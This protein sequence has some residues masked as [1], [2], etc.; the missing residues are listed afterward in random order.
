MIRK[1]IGMAVAAAALAAS[2]TAMAGFNEQATDSHDALNQVFDPSLPAPGGVTFTGTY[3]TLGTITLD[4]SVSASWKVTYT[5][6]GRE[7]AYKD[8]MVFDMGAGSFTNKNTALGA[9]F[10]FTQSAGLMDFQFYD[11]MGYGTANGDVFGT[12]PLISW[13]LLDG[14]SS[15]YGPFDYII[16]LNDSAGGN[17]R[18]YDDMVIGITVTPVPEPE[19]YALMLAGLGCVTLVARRR[20]KR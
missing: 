5:F 8:T 2:G 20:M 18:D 9:S 12:L 16:G 11:V 1:T 19:S 15:P 7:A 14:A 17:L 6:L 3:A 13:G 10:S 4:A